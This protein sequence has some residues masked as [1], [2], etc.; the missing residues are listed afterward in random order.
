M[1]IAIIHGDF[2]E[3]SILCKDSEKVDFT[4]VRIGDTY[5]KDF[6]CYLF[7]TINYFDSN[8][9]MKTLIRS[10]DEF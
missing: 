2:K 4:C 9:E 7:D 1:T 5:S 10:G 3:L 6:C 8:D